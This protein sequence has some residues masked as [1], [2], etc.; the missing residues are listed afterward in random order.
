MIPQHKRLHAHEFV[1]RA[2][3]NVGEEVNVNHD[4]CSAG[5]DTKKR[6]Y[7]KRVEGGVVSYCHHCGKAGYFMFGKSRFR[8]PAGVEVPVEA[9]DYKTPEMEMVKAGAAA[10]I[11]AILEISKRR[12]KFKDPAKANNF[13]LWVAP[14]VEGVPLIFGIFAPFTA[15]E[16]GYQLRWLDGRKPK[17]KTYMKIKPNPGQLYRHATDSDTLVIVEDPISA[18]MINACTVGTKMDV[19]CL[20]GSHLA[21]NTEVQLG[22]YKNTLVWLDPDKA[23]CKAADEISQRLHFLYPDM[24]VKNLCTSYQPKDMLYFDEILNDEV[25]LLRSR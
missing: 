15:T 4:D 16:V 5:M 13:N 7:I 10:N 3:S 9:T 6:L 21:R 17:S 2:P 19:L 1:N 18:Y 25:L 14:K 8:T 11:N 12:D 20:F 22:V 23:G 24:K